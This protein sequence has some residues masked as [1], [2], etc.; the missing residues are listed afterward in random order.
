MTTANKQINRPAVRADMP[1]AL[2]KKSRLTWLLWLIPAAAAALCVWFVYRDFVATGPLITIYFQNAE[3]LEN[4]NTDI[5]Y[6]GATVG[7]VKTVELAPDLRLVKVRARL[8]DSAKE[9]AKK[10]SAFWI[11][12]PEVRLGAISGLRTIVSGEY[13]AVQ[14]GSGERTNVFVG[15]EKQPIPQEP[16]ALRITLL[17]PSLGSLQEQ[18]PI[19]YRG[20]TVGQVLYYQLAPDAHQVLVH[21]RIA[22][23]YKPLV[24]MNSAFWNAGGLDFHFGLLKGMQ[25]T[26]ESPK[27][28]ISGGIEFATPPELGPP[29]SNDTQFVVHE[30]PEEKWKS[31]TPTIALHLSQAAE[32]TNA[33]MES[34]LK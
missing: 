34:Y 9:L 20:L 5:R 16:N 18:S 4:Q 14:P 31:W 8:S 13:I 19:F 15:Y 28:L 12:R 22:E 10:G 11:V 17:L 7:Q 30:K 32:I 6:R 3:G 21:A 24:R 26:A 25:L 1:R 23:E 27:T 33:P 29:A 2:V